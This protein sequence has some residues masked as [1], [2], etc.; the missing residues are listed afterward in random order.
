MW[1]EYDL[2]TGART[3]IRDLSPPDRSG[4]IGGTLDDWSDRDG[5]YAYM[6]QRSLST[7]FLV[8]G[9]R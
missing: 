5:A 2:T 1:S 9:A 6:Y 7:L 8:A 3:A 4:V